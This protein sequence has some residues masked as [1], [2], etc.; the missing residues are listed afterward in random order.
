MTPRSVYL[1]PVLELFL[2]YGS[3]FQQLGCS[4]TSN[5][6]CSTI[7]YLLPVLP[8]FS[9]GATSLPAA[10]GPIC[11]PSLA[12]LLLLCL[13]SISWM[14]VLFLFSPAPLWSWVS[15]LTSSALGSPHL[16]CLSSGLALRN[17]PPLEYCHAL[18]HTFLLP[19]FLHPPNLSF[20]T[21]AGLT[22]LEHIWWSHYLLKEFRVSPT[23][24]PID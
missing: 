8:I 6:I 20:H 21:A 22:I 11:F 23:P 13:R 19:V 18:L 15:I 12:S 7:N 10:Q 2:N 16:H 14:C 17:P 5:S 1:W 4:G 24:F 9:N 3:H